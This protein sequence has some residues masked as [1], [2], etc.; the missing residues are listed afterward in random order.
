MKSG[1][2]ISKWCV[3]SSTMTIH[4]NVYFDRS[5]RVQPIIS[6][7]R[8]WSCWYTTHQ[9]GV[10][11]LLFIMLW[12]E[13]TSFEKSHL[14]HVHWCH[15]MPFLFIKQKKGLVLPVHKSNIP[16]LLEEATIYAESKSKYSTSQITPVSVSCLVCLW[17]SRSSA[18]STGVL[19][20][21]LL[22]CS[23]SCLHLWKLS[24]ISCHNKVFLLAE[25]E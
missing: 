10:N 7:R 3:Q 6:Q 2:R 19:F 25:Q 1:L 14:I 8:T 21:W 9:V 16:Q 12:L 15:M 17:I 11:I 20:L 23:E 24:H 5:N 18:H 4:V 22:I 13:Q